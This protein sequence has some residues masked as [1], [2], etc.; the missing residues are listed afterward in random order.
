MMDRRAF[1]YGSG[2]TVL[3]AWLANYMSM[4]P[5]KAE[6][7][8]LKAVGDG[9]ELIATLTQLI[10]QLMREAAVPGLSIA[11]VQDGKLRWQKAFGVKDTTSR[12]PVDEHTAFEAASVSKTVFAYAVLK[13][14]EKGVIGLDTPLDRYA[15]SPLPDA[16][17]R[18]GSI[19]ARHVL[20]HTTGFQ[21]I[22]SGDEP[23]K[24]HFQPGSQ[25]DYSGEGYWYLQSIVS[26]VAGHENPNDCG[27]YEA[28]VKICATDIDAFLKSNL[29][30]PFGMK[31]S[32]YVWNADLARRAA[33]P[34][35]VTGKALAKSQPKATDAARYAAMGGLHTTSVDYAK[36]LIEVLDPKPADAY[37]LNQRNHDEML[38]PQVKLKE[39]EKIDGADAWALGWAIQQRK[40]GDVILHSG[41]QSGFRSLTMG[42]VQR[43]SGFVMLTN[44]DNGGNVLFHPKLATALTPLLTK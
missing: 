4:T 26:R 23:L 27:E 42:S 32:G 31:T 1:L 14:C 39:G 41:G 40:T 10:P 35:D 19:T 8:T 6:A 30:V 29:L 15:P 21:N 28:G 43:K 33:H 2:Q 3:S 17:P 37:R 20:S 5:Q 12:E 22:R 13:Q 25:F 16:D 18:F 11:L 24:I 36:F 38:T 7:A 9:E 34:H 44:S